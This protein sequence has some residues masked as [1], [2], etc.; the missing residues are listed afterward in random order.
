VVFDEGLIE[1]CTEPVSTWALFAFET[2]NDCFY[3]LRSYGDFLN[4]L[5]VPDLTSVPGTC[6]GNCPIPADI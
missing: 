5:S 1:F 2:F 6:L 4:G 3:F